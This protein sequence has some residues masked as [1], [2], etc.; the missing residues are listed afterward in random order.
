MF[1]EGR[2]WSE[3]RRGRG[4]ER[5]GEWNLGDRSA[6][7]F[8]GV[9]IGAPCGIISPKRE[10]T[11]QRGHGG[12]T[13]PTHGPGICVTCYMAEQGD[14]RPGQFAVAIA[15]LGRALCIESFRWPFSLEGDQADLPPLELEDAAERIAEVVADLVNRLALP[16]EPIVLLLDSELP[17]PARSTA[18]RLI[19]AETVLDIR[20]EDLSKEEKM[21][22]F[23][24]LDPGFG[25]IKVS[26][27]N[28]R[29]VVLPA[30]FTVSTLAENPEAD[31]PLFASPPP[32]GRP[33]HGLPPVHRVQI[34]EAVFAVGHI[35]LR[36]VA[37]RRLDLARFRGGPD[38][39]ALLLAAF[40]NLFPNARE[41][42]VRAVV[43]LPVAIPRR[44]EIA[45]AFR[46]WLTAA[47]H[48]GRVDHHSL[49]VIFDEVRLV[50]QPKGAY[51]LYVIGADGNV[52][53]DRI[54]QRVGVVDI[55]Y[56]TL[57]ISVF[58]EGQEEGVHS[59]GA[60]LGIWRAGELLIRAGQ[61]GTPETAEAML[62]NEPDNP[63]VKSALY[64][65]GVDIA[66]ALSRAMMGQAALAEVNHWILTGGGVTF[67][68][69]QQA[70]TQTLPPGRF[71]IPRNPVVANAMGMALAARL[72]WGE[73]E[74][75]EK[76]DHAR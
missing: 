32:A 69:I 35:G 6:S 5:V 44:S 49:T 23:I 56:H 40:H 26:M 24:G 25:N 38:L 43:G 72:L 20:L 71:S 74:Q 53:P 30:T 15:I 31:L 10:G 7:P 65:L 16:P 8:A 2:D 50:H 45:E 28:S 54:R 41:V 73:K 36:A 64:Q 63:F 13:G 48:Q 21:N 29:S 62:R 70:I 58:R 51:Y 52:R 9:T 12:F 39:Q 1:R 59:I 67:P 68:E 34:G 61:A 18:M 75:E 66:T 19:Q 11:V 4:E 46:S 14:L 17:P 57:D 42:R 76:N 55:G 60:E 22:T 47:P 3:G 27:P 33:R 37:T